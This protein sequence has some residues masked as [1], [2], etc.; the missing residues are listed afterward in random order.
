MEEDDQKVITLFPTRLREFEEKNNLVFQHYLGAKNDLKLRRHSE[1]SS[2]GDQYTRRRSVDIDAIDADEEFFNTMQ[3][4]FRRSSI[5]TEFPQRKGKLEVLETRLIP[6]IFG[7][8]GQEYDTEEMRRWIKANDRHG[9]GVVDF[10]GY[11]RICVHFLKDPEA[12]QKAKTEEFSFQNLI[13]EDEEDEDDSD[14]Q[15]SD[16]SI[17]E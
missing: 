13:Q 2:F 14:D 9:L 3:N 6:K 4:I 11:Q 10:N 5:T 1:N 12:I 7:R 17:S 8:M 15:N 16:L